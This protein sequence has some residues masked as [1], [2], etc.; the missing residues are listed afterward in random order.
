MTTTNQLPT[1]FAGL[2]DAGIEYAEFELGNPDESDSNLGSWLGA[3]PKDGSRV[4]VFAQDGTGSLFGVWLRPEHADVET[5][6]VIYL[7]S[8]G[9]TAVLAKDPRAFIELLGSAMTFDGH[10]GTFFS[11]DDD[12]DEEIGELR[13]RAAS[14]AK[15]TLGLAKLRKPAVIKAEAEAAYPGLQ[16]WVDAHNAHR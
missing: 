8:E 14:F 9:E 4:V 7:G 2:A 13:K 10:A 3:L 12:E 6:P 16:A 11:M 1:I 5:A 15:R